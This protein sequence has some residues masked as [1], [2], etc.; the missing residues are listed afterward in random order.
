MNDEFK[1][2]SA[3]T[4]VTYT[5]EE[6]SEGSV[7]VRLCPICGRFVK[8]DESIK[9]NMDGRPLPEPNAN[10]KKHGRIRMHFYLWLSDLFLEE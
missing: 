7:F 5:P 10:C 8:P 9:V 3:K 2:Y 6:G 4:L 1:E